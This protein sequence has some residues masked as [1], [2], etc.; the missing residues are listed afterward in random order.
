MEEFGGKDSFFRR[1]KKEARGKMLREE[2]TIRDRS[3][4]IREVQRGNIAVD[5]LIGK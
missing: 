5:L 1:K 2:K 3:T 4:L